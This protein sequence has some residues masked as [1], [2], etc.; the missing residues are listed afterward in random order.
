WPVVGGA[1]DSA[2]VASGPSAKRYTIGKT[3]H[4]RQNGTP[5]AKRYTIGKT[6][7]HRQNALP[8]V[9]TAAAMGFPVTPKF[10]AFN[11]KIPAP[12]AVTACTRAA[13]GRRAGISRHFRRCPEGIPMPSAAYG[14]VHRGFALKLSQYIYEFSQCACRAAMLRSVYSGRNGFACSPM[15][16]GHQDGIG[17]C[18]RRGNLDFFSPGFL[19]WHNVF[20]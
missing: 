7:H 11:L 20:E 15:V 12:V 16:A 18:Q 4:H 8:L 19:T 14:L 17:M 6:V 10:S 3:V 5:S 13:T 9:F 1:S 2:G